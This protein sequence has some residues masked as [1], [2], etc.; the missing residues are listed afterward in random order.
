VAGK[1][2]AASIYVGIW[3]CVLILLLVFTPRLSADQWWSA[4]LSVLILI[5][6]TARYLDLT[7]YQRGILLDPRQRRL[8]GAE[9]SLVLLA[10]NL[11]EVT[12]IG[13]VDA[14]SCVNGLELLDDLRGR[15]CADVGVDRRFLEPLPG[16]FARRRR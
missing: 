1:R 3:L 12:L 10:L 8:Q 7:T 15:A 2:D 9:R 11:V 13:G 16:L 6:A 5:A 4:L 14:P